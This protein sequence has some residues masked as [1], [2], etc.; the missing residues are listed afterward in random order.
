MLMNVIKQD[1]AE[2]PAAVLLG[3][4]E[5]VLK[6]P[7]ILS[8]SIG[9]AYP[10]ADVDE[11]GTS[12]IVVA[13]GNHSAASEGARWLALEAWEMRHQ[14]VGDL[15]TPAE[16]IREAAAFDD[17]PVVISDIGD[18]IG[19]G[20]PG[21]S[22]VLLE[23]MLRQ[24]VPNGLVVL[25]DP[26][27]VQKCV[28]A[29]VGSQANL[30]VGS[31]TAGQPGEPV[32]IS[33][34][35]RTI[36]DGLFFE[37]KPRHGGRSE[38]N[39]G[40]TA[41]VET[42]QRHTIV[43]TSLRMAPMSLHQILSL[44]IDPKAKKVITVKAAIAPRAAYM[45]VAAHFI[46]ANTPGATSADLQSFSYRHRRRPLFPWEPEAEYAGGENPNG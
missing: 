40:L 4:L 30:R 32:T 43:L 34:R 37:P 5:E 39:Q 35:V 46:L 44:G 28:T 19:G 7:S 23:E 6:R 41:V 20:A 1:S 27:A 14:F 15:P 45:P 13:D 21:D 25:W 9:Y 17:Q 24:D 2:A 42:E 10:W 26:G 38:N 3:R 18:N 33:G 36:S 11:M 12:I 22:T 31:K 8:A 16:A 29:G